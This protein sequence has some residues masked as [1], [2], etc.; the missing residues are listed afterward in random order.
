MDSDFYFKKNLDLQK[1]CKHPK[2]NHHM[3]LHPLF[4]SCS[5]LT[6]Y[7]T[8]LETNT[9]L[10]NTIHWTADFTDRWQFSHSGPFSLPSQGPTLHLV[11]VSPQS[12]PSWV[13]HFSL[14]FHDLGIWDEHWSLTLGL[15]WVF[16]W[17]AWSYVQLLSVPLTPSITLGSTGGNATQCHDVKVMTAR[18][19]L[20]P[21]FLGNESLRTTLRQEEGN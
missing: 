3:L 15:F 1:S 9:Y 10:Y 19:L 7:C 20:L 2:D 13:S 8:H 6:N 16:S 14:A 18:F 5:H 21:P 17:L 4:F 12:P 11:S